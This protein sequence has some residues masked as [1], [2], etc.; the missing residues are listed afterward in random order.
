M[1]IFRKGIESEKVEDNGYPAPET[2]PKYFTPYFEVR[3]IDNTY[4]E[5]RF[6]DAVF[7]KLPYA[8]TTLESDRN[9]VQNPGWENRSYQ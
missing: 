3:P 7:Y 5:R 8:K 4:Y 2:D 1:F 6:N 9:L